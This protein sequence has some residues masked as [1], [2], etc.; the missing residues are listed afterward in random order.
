MPDPVVIVLEGAEP[1]V[2][3][4]S[5]MLR[6][7]LDADVP[8]GQAGVVG[9]Y[10]TFD[11][12]EWLRAPDLP[13]ELARVDEHLANARESGLGLLLV[14]AGEKNLEC[15]DADVRCRLEGEGP[16]VADGLGRR[17][18]FSSS[19]PRVDVGATRVR[20]GFGFIQFR[21][22][23]PSWTGNVALPLVG[24]HNV[25][26]ALAAIS[27]LELL[28]VPERAIVEPLC[29]V[30]VPGHTEL[31]FSP[32]QHVMALLEGGR[33]RTCRRRAL[34]AARREF[35]GTAIETPVGSGIDLAVER[36]YGRAGQTLL[37]LLG[38]PEENA[39]AFQAAVRRHANWTG[40]LRD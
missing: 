4:A 25:G 11:G 39:D 14:E 28:G 20:A 37:V 31:L 13:S 24:L 21:A 23:T 34:E 5:S 7:V 12:A 22:H 33:S 30:R 2:A 6:T 32:D 36:A 29:L 9:A 3:A 40:T 26:P 19:S 15:V 8:Y 10:E 18:T 16:G 1:D 38:Q 27:V 35:T 17:L